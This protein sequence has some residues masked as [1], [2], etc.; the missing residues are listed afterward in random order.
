LDGQ[1]H[2]WNGDIDAKSSPFG[3]RDHYEEIQFNL[4]GSWVNKDTGQPLK[5]PA[6]GKHTVRVAIMCQPSEKGAMERKR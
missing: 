4:R 6:P 2:R 5:F 3:P 1:W